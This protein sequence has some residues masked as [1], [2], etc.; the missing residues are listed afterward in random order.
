[1]ASSEAAR[2]TSP[3][4][5]AALS[6]P[7]SQLARKQYHSKREARPSRLFSQTGSAKGRLFV[8]AVRRFL[9]AGRRRRLSHTSRCKDP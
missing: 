5:R 1:M 2:V 7:L 6:P 4:M 9:P 3:F 8:R